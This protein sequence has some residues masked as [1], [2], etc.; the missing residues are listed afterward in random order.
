MRAGLRERDS[1]ERE[2][3]PE[4]WYWEMLMELKD[5]YVGPR[6]GTTV[7]VREDYRKPH[8]QGAIGTINKH[9]EG[10]EYTAYEVSFPTGRRSCSGS[11]SSREQTT[12]LSSLR[13]GGGGSSGS[14]PMTNIG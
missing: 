7:R 10:S 2:G 3:R 11:T 4:F 1:A 6:A 5:A 13:S 9:Y 8:R 12:Y 14:K